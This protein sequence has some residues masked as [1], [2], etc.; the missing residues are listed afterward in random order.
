MIRHLAVTAALCAALL[1]VSPVPAFA[2]STL[3]D[4]KVAGM[5]GERPDGLVG[6]V[7]PAA[8]AQVKKMVEEINAQRRQR[9]ESIA[10]NNGTSLTKVQ[11]VAGQ[12]LVSRTPAGQFV[13]NPAG[14]WMRK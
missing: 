4:A 11:A 6:V 8:S 14:A 5:V 10:A 3:E 12:E 2:Q 7:S 13:M 1:A 9:Y